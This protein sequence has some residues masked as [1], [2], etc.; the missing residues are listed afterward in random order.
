MTDRNA[1]VLDPLARLLCE[2]VE[3]TARDAVGGLG[4]ERHRLVGHAL[5]RDAANITAIGELEQILFG[6]RHMITPP[7][8]FILAVFMLLLLLSIP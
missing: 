7:A 4:I 6:Y 3:E 5:D 8:R 1:Q 2:E